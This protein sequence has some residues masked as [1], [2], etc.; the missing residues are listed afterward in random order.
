M[1]NPTPKGNLK[2]LLEKISNIR[3]AIL[4]TVDENGVLRSRPM[5]SIDIDADNNIWFFTKEDSEKIEEVNHYAQVSLAYADIDN[6]TYVSISGTGSISRDKEKMQE[7]WNPMVKAWFPKGLE[8][9]NIA[10]LQVKIHEAE[11][12]DANASRMVRLYHLAKA[13]LTGE[14]Y[15]GGEHKQVSGL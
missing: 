12:W 6:Q 14:R 3:I 10:L 8:E 11:Y 15:D 5:A 7:L 1:D 9:P 4:T 13:L 2:D